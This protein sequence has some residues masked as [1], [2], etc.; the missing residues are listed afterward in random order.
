MSEP[1]RHHYLPE[2]YLDLFCRNGLLWV[3]DRKRKEYRQQTSKNTAVQNQYYSA[4]GPDDKKHTRV[5]Q[6]LSVIEGLAKP[7]IV[8]IS[9]EETISPQDKEVLA[10][11]VSFLKVRVPDFE[12][13]INEMTEKRLKIQHEFMFS[14][15]ENTAIV[16]KNLEVKTGKKIDV[17][18][19]DFMEF[20]LSGQY[21]IKFSREYS[22]EIMLSFGADLI[23]FFLN[24]DWVFL[25]APDKSSFV[26]SDNPFALVPPD[27]YNPKGPYGFGLITLG[28]RK[29]VPLT[30]RTCLVM[31]DYG[32]RVI[33]SA[34][35]SEEVRNINLNI[36]VAC[37]NLL[38]AKDKPL[39]EKLVKMTKI[40]EWQ[41]ESR[42]RVG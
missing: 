6:F 34:I 23:R 2:F 28:A 14:S 10:V 7:V 37:D 27:D 21:D 29:V 35:K 26:T 31:C 19:K 41:I 15:E 1:K 39:L 24:M 5:E 33:K 38:I 25:Y 32:Q 11:F 9:N 8:K 20:V 13:T 3:Y 42:V 17:S 4:F 36:T 16:L 22:L 40:N 30:Q 12:K 18:P